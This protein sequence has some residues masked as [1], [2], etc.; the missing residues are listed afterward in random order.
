MSFPLLTYRVKGKKHPPA[1]TARRCERGLHMKGKTAALA[2]ACALALLGTACGSVQTTEET[3]A[4]H[5]STAAHAQENGAGW[6]AAGDTEAEAVAEAVAEAAG[7]ALSDGDA[8]APAADRQVIRTANL[9]LE[10]KQYDEALALVRGAA[11]E[12]GGY[13]CS[14]SPCRPW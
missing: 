13:I 8:G 1:E 7:E 14:P 10:T 4:A 5:G 9:S 3:A 2:L 12:S 6:S 11:A